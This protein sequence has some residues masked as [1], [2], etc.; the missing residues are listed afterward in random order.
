[1][2]GVQAEAREYAVDAKRRHAG[3][4][5]PRRSGRFPANQADACQEQAEE[6]SRKGKKQEKV[7]RS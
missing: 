7:H 5:A 4:E 2:S 1:L 3:E 6:P